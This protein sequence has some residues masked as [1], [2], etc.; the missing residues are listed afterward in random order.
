MRRRSDLG[1]I[2]PPTRS[3]AGLR[4]G[5][6]KRLGSVLR[7]SPV[8]A[9]D[10][11]DRRRFIERVELNGPALVGA[12]RRSPFANLLSH[13]LG[14]RPFHAG[15]V[16]FGPRSGTR[17]EARSSRGRGCA[18]LRGSQRTIGVGPGLSLSG[19]ELR[20]RRFV[21]SFQGWGGEEPHRFDARLGGLGAGFRFGAT[22]TRNP[23]PRP[24]RGLLGRRLLTGGRT[25]RCAGGG[26]PVRRAPRRGALAGRAFRGG[27]E[28]GGGRRR[29]VAGLIG[30]HF[31]RLRPSVVAHDAGTPPAS[32]CDPSAR[33][34]RFREF[35]VSHRGLRNAS[36]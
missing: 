1:R 25:T 20:Q 33:G 11:L 14:R 19:Q 2:G 4:F 8:G 36:H 31:G 24:R 16:R 29:A 27:R 13:G 15:L 32:G 22:G 17:R 28:C 10:R 35:R 18:G 30:H 5:I 9:S 3:F 7:R 23:R 34:F 12:A 6:R 26:L 21:A